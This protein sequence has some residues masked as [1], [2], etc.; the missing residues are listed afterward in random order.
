MKRRGFDPFF[1]SSLPLIAATEAKP[2]LAALFKPKE[3]SW[4]CSGCFCRNSAETIKCP[5]CETLKPGAAPPP[6]AAATTQ[7]AGRWRRRRRDAEPLRRFFFLVFVSTEFVW[8]VARL[9]T[10]RP[11]LRVSSSTGSH[12]L[13][14]MQFYRVLPM[15]AEFFTQFYRVFGVFTELSVELPSS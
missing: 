10:A 5:A 7:P 11:V 2:S 14:V 12:P 8:N 9:C 13:S 15:G 4:E 3:G 1:L 6:A